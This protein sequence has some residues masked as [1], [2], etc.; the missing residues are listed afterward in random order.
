MSNNPTQNFRIL[1]KVLSKK[2][3]IRIDLEGKYI[4]LEEPIVFENISNLEI[5]NG[6]IISERKKLI[7][8]TFINSKNIKIINVQFDFKKSGIGFLRFNQCKE[9]LVEKCSFL[10]L[11]EGNHNV[12]AVVYKGCQSI[13]IRDNLF[14]NIVGKKVSRA[15]KQSDRVGHLSYDC[16][17]ENNQINNIFPVKDGDGIYIESPNEIGLKNQFHVSIVGN[18]F[19]N[20]AKR[21]IKIN[22]SNV[23]IKGNT[24]K[25]DLKSMYAFISV[26]G[27]NINI[28]GNEFEAVNTYLAVGIGTNKDIKNIVINKNRFTTKSGKG[29]TK[30]VSIQSNC[31]D[32][33]I[34][35]NFIT[36]FHFPVT[37]SFKSNNSI[38]NI[39]L[40]NNY[41]VDNSACFLNLTGNHKNIII[42]E[43]T[44][45][46]STNTKMHNISKE[47]SST[48]QVIKNKKIKRQ[49]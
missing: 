12:N 40:E 44:L 38:E 49:Q 21:F 6:N 15:I 37:T 20:N 30:G 22:A 32:I 33:I 1:H 10:N 42:K 5:R 36:G 35:D 43:N 29:K 2:N 7:G 8:F 18:K 34:R 39:T 24:G 13:R 23:L 16:V 27:G 45:E 31:K 17:I 3:L 48:I 25:S 4:K 46:S 47:K 9:V 26:F 14:D 11:G 41:V 19:E 28:E